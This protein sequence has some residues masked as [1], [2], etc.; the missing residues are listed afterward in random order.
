MIVVVQRS[1]LFV[2]WCVSCA[3]DVV[4]MLFPSLGKFHWIILL[5]YS[6]TYIM[7]I[8]AYIVLRLVLQDRSRTLLAICCGCMILTQP[9]YLGVSFVLVS[10]F[11]PFAFY[12]S[13]VVSPIFLVGAITMFAF[14][15]WIGRQ[16]E[17]SAVGGV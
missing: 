13:M 6:S 1:L 5:Y 3:Y 15:L 14:I 4:R 9:V 16:R 8:V 11:G 17:K 2:S 12:V 10:I 7:V